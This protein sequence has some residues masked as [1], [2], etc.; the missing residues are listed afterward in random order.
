MPS[1]AVKLT[2][3]DWL[4]IEREACKRSL[5]EFVRCG[6]SSIEAAEYEHGWHIDAICEHLEAISRGD[7]KRLLITVP[8]GTMKSLLTAVF[9]P[10]WEL[11]PLGRP[12]T[13]ILAA[14]H[15]QELATR[16]NRKCRLLIQ[17]EWYQRLWGD[18]V[19]IVSDQNQKQKFET[20][21]GG[22]RQAT[23]RR[24]LSPL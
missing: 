4:N 13:R 19:K 20:L 16:D 23:A 5:A 12:H 1:A 11:G 24:W 6:W 21:Q 14:S 9:W 18:Q 2:E 10:A 8:P 17:S 7:I 15:A 3:A 22:F